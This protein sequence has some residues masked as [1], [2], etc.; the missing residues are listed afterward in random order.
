[1][2]QLRELRAPERDAALPAP[3]ARRLGL[4]G[5]ASARTYVGAAT[6]WLAARP[7]RAWCSSPEDEVVYQAFLGPFLGF[8]GETGTLCSLVCH[9]PFLVED[10]GA[11]T[12]LLLPLLQRGAARAKGTTGSP[13]AVAD[14]RR[15][16]PALNGFDADVEVVW[17]ALVAA[18]R[19][20]GVRLGMILPLATIAIDAPRIAAAPE[21]VHW[22]QA[23]PEETLAGEAAA[24]A[25][26][27]VEATPAPAALER[28]VAAPE[29]DALRAV[30]GLFVAAD[31]H[32]RPVTVANAY[33]DPVAADAATYTWRDV[34]AIRFTRDVAPAPH[35]GPVRGGENPAASAFI[36]AVLAHRVSADGGALL[37]D[38]SSALPAT[39]LAGCVPPYPETMLVA[40]QLWSY[41]ERAPF[42]FVTGPLVPCV[43]AHT[44]APAVLAR[45]LAHHLSLLAESDDARWFFAGA[46]N[47]DSV[48]CPERWTRALLTLFCLLPRSVPFVYSGTEMAS[49]A[50]TNLEFGDLG[51]QP[52]PPESELLLFSQ[53][54]VAVDVAALTRFT[55]FWRDLLA[56]RAALGTAGGAPATI[57]G[58]AQ[59]GLVVSARI[60]GVLVAVNCSPSASA[61]V[62]VEETAAVLG[63]APLTRRGG[64]VEL[65]PVSTLVAAPAGL[66]RLGA[67]FT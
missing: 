4:P 67:F 3:V 47:H 49:E 13:F 44:R 6:D 14:H 48:P 26:W 34:A 56:L 39:V 52:H 58:V 27:Q 54:A 42:E 38:V 55:A 33:P 65:E 59:D 35:R 12:V 61:C 37:A 43:A 32:G 18:C 46:A 2:T 11:T 15:L 31:A 22:W 8:A 25:P 17:A 64:T 29:P 5:A 66:S 60:A 63:T 40:E 28:F 50:P 16:D 62:P 9:L 36:R 10:L 23:G 1:V 20:I 41:R 24:G 45:S 21:L 30:D 53:S 57:T 51:G 7:A 19:R